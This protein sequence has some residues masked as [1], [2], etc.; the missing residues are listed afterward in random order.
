[1][2]EERGVTTVVAALRS[3]PGT[4]S[5]DFTNSVKLCVYSVGL[6]VTN[7]CV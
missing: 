6:C 4:D 7:K 2:R 3:H 5:T 1:M